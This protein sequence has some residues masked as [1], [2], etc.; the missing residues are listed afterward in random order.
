MFFFVIGLNP[1]HVTPPV[2]H[3]QGKKKTRSKK[4]VDFISNEKQDRKKLYE[5]RVRDQLAKD[6]QTIDQLATTG[7]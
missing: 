1:I 2:R 7:N 6:Q 5:Q 3:V 4:S